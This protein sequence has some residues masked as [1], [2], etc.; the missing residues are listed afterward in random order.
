ME[1]ASFY[2][3]LKSPRAGML[4]QPPELWAAKALSQICQIF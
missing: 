2:G 3:A 1:A 4:E